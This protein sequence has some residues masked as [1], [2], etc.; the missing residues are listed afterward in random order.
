MRNESLIGLIGAIFGF[1]ASLF[2]I[3][4]AAT[5]AEKLTAVQVALFSALGLGGAGIILSQPRFGG[6]MMILSSE[7]L[8]LTVPITS[9]IT[10]PLSYLPAIVCFGL[11]GIV[12]LRDVNKIENEKSP[13]ENPTAEPEE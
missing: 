2:L 9:P 4:S 13:E 11:A 10:V 8:I 3:L 5:P 1:C 7:F 6:W 12:V